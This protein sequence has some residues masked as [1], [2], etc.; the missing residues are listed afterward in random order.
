VPLKREV[1]AAALVCAQAAFVEA[2]VIIAQA[3]WAIGAKDLRFNM[4]S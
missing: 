4:V 2:I 1:Q 3:A